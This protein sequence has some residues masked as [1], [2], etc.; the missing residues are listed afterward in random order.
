MAS[1]SRTDAQTFH[2]PPAP[3]PNC[4]SEAAYAADAALIFP[5]LFSLFDSVQYR[6]N[7]FTFNFFSRAGGRL[8]GQRSRAYNGVHGFQQLL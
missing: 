3:N 8:R 4:R 1:P 6:L 7:V 2:F 5:L